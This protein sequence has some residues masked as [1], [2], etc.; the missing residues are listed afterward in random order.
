MSCWK[1]N[2]RP[3]LGLLMETEISFL[4]SF[5]WTKIRFK[6]L[7][8]VSLNTHQFLQQWKT[9]LQHDSTSTVLHCVAGVLRVMRNVGFLPL[10]KDWI[11][12]PGAM[13]FLKQLLKVRFAKFTQPL[14]Y[15]QW[16]W[17][18]TTPVVWPVVVLLEH[19][20]LPKSQSLDW[21]WNQF[22]R[23]TLCFALSNLSS[24]QTSFA[25]YENHSCRIALPPPC[26]TVWLVFSERWEGF[27]PLCK[28]PK[29][30][31]WSHHIRELFSHVFA[32][33]LKL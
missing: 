28:H 31:H 9:F 14:K 29:I 3:S 20:P 27:L 23:T 8:C 33:A 19:E 22:S 16:F 2:L 30:Q 1:R 26:F 5:H 12:T 10:C 24:S 17:F 4:K 18:W 11:E 15:I 32:W 13:F 21:D 7:P 25:G 6:G